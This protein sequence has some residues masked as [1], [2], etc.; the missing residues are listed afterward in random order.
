M[1]EMELLERRLAEAGV[2]HTK[3]FSDPEIFTNGLPYRNQIRVAVAGAGDRC[4]SA[5]CHFGSYGAKEG[6]IECWDFFG[7]PEGYLTAGEAF[8]YIM[9]RIGGE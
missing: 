6:L 1:T 8:D 2:Q 4:V 3:Y 5:V 9:S 7:E